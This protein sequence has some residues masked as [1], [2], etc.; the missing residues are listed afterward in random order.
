MGAL[1]ASAAG[2]QV[3]GQHGAGGPQRQDEV[4][5]HPVGVARVADDV[6]TVCVPFN[7]IPAPSL[8]AAFAIRQ[9]LPEQCGRR[10]LSPW[11]ISRSTP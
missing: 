7:P 3:D 5:W 11:V 8:I 10:A 1:G 6:H 4:L 2:V 9:R